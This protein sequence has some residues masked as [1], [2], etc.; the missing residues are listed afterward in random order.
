M[1][2]D[3][4]ILSNQPPNNRMVVAPT[5]T[6]SSSSSSCAYVMAATLAV[7]LTLSCPRTAASVWHRSSVVV[8]YA[9]LMALLR[10]LSRTSDPGYVTAESMELNSSEMTDLQIGPH[11]DYDCSVEE[12]FRNKDCESLSITTNAHRHCRKYCDTCG[13]APPLRS[14]HCKQCGACVATFDHHCGFLGVC[15]GERNHCRFAV[16]VVMQLAGFLAC[17]SIVASSE[18]GLSTLLFHN[19]NMNTTAH[20][21]Y[22][23]WSIVL[24]I[25]AKT[26]IYT[27]LLPAALIV[28]I[29]AFFAAT[30]STS[31]E[32]S[33]SHRVDYFTENNVNAMDLP[34]STGSCLLNLYNFYQR[35]DG[36]SLI[37]S[38]PSHTCAT[39]WTPV[40]WQLRPQKTTSKCE[41]MPQNDK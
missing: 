36:Y 1:N 38:Q 31:F 40:P 4:I 5:G 15:V 30:N 14:H 17:A 27:L 25:L 7:L 39:K 35:D 32:F 33:K 26:Y 6:S 10:N 11:D 21:T 24:A 12:S 16:F 8:L 20:D 34:F 37:V 18:L 41:T 3:E 28:V 23:F 9:V 13:L 2:N 19:N 22:E 29:H